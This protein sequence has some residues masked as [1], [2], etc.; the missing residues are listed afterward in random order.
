MK[1]KVESLKRNLNAYHVCLQ[2]MLICGLKWKIA[3]RIH[4]EILLHVFLLFL[5]NKFG[6]EC[7]LIM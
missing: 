6:A 4:V 1:I 7:S 3:S 2:K 5:N